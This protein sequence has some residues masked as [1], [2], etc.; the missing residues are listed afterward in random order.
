M[1]RQKS[2]K[3]GAMLELKFGDLPDTLCGMLRRKR[4][5]PRL[6]ARLPRNYT[7]EGRY[8][9]LVYLWGWDG[10][11]VDRKAFAY[12]RKLTADRDFIAVNMPLFKKA[13]DPREIHQGVMIRAYDDYQKI[14]RCYRRM[15]GARFKAVPNID[16]TRSVFGGLSNGAHTT[17]LLLS[18]VDPFILKHFAG[19]FLL[20]GGW[21]IASSHKPAVSS[22]R[23]ISFIGARRRTKMRRALLDRM[24]ATTA[25][26]NMPHFTVVK[27]PGVEHDFPADYIPTLRSWMY[28]ADKSAGLAGRVRA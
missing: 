1:I 24:E 3:P 7:R 17:A 6:I 20:E 2:L 19:F 27:M 28:G 15:L 26:R 25:L 14:S 4:I 23:V 11:P 9:L 13:L 5:P 12:V 18:A 10:G 8:P 16:P 22:K 21:E